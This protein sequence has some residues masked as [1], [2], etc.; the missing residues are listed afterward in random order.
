M[1]SKTEKGS[2]A[3]KQVSV[4]KVPG[5]LYHENGHSKTFGVLGP[6]YSVQYS[7][8]VALHNAWTSPYQKVMSKATLGRKW[9]ARSSAVYWQ[10]GM[11]TYMGSSWLGRVDKSHA[12]TARG[13]LLIAGD[14]NFLAASEWTCVL[15]AADHAKVMGNNL[16]QLIV[17]VS[18]ILQEKEIVEVTKDMR[19]GQRF[20]SATKI[21]PL[22]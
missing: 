11:E 8:Y 15:A 5:E 7:G 12:K 14:S 18:N 16:S 4:I 1:L 17:H 6:K 21:P 19:W 10:C 13:T 9:S 3:W 2:H 22:W 20:C